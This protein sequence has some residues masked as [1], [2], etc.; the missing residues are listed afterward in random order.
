MAKGS[1]SERKQLPGGQW[2]YLK[3]IT[4][5]QKEKKKEKRRCYTATGILK[6]ENNN[7]FAMFKVS[8]KFAF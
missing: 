5:K 2:E 6:R 7:G 8:T 1:Q 4:K 3:Q